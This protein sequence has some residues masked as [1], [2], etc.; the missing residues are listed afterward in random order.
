MGVMERLRVLGCDHLNLARGKYLAAS[1]LDAGRTRTFPT[2]ASPPIAV[3]MHPLWK[4][5]VIAMAARTTST[6]VLGTR[7]PHVE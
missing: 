2:L 3:Y 7:P 6:Q 5:I 4:G 1:K